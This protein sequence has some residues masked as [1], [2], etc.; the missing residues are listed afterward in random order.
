M[1]RYRRTIEDRTSQTLSGNTTLTG[2]ER[3]RAGKERV[4]RA[5]MRLFPQ[6]RLVCIGHS[7]TRAIVA[8]AQNRGVRLTSIDFWSTG[9]PVV[10]DA[11]PRRFR[12]DI[13]E[14]LTGKVFSMV[15]GAAFNI[16]GLCV[17][18]RRFDFVLPSTPHLPFDPHAEIVPF[19]AVRA[20]LLDITQPFLDLMGYIRDAAAGP[21]YQ[22]EAPPPFV[23]DGRMLAEVFW[24]DFEGM[25]REISPPHFR[26]K[27][28]R[29]HSEIVQQF[30]TKRNITF[31]PR[32][33]EAVDADGYLL[34]QFYGDTMHV[35]EDYGALVLEQMRRVK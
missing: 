9:Q 4:R 28:W 15:G 19:G 14:Q 13:A 12:A 1:N 31:I 11:G 21:V 27:L 2:D 24:P 32:P 26:F 25:R 23:D 6:P 8:A 16:M 20:A 7:H 18:P 34:S 17:H 10:V 33:P 5:L 35:N 22:I 3:L 29:L 30:C